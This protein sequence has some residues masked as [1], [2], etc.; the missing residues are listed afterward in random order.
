[1]HHFT[2]KLRGGLVQIAKFWCPRLQQFIAHVPK[3]VFGSIDIYG[4]ANGGYQRL[5]LLERKV[6]AIR[7]HYELLEVWMTL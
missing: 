3:V 2:Q 7:Q 4:V 5:E 1:M 6:I